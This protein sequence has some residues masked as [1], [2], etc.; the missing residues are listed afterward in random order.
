MNFRKI[1]LG[2]FSLLLLFSSCKKD[3]D[4]GGPAVVER[5]RTE[6]QLIDNDSLVGYLETHYYNSSL[7][8][9]PG[10]YG[11]SDIVIE[12]LDQDEDG[13]YLPL[14]DP[15]NTTLL[16]DAVGSPRT[17]T[18]QDVEYT[19]YVLSLNEGGGVMP[20]FCDSVRLNY[21]GM[22]QD[23][24]VFDST[25]TPATFDLMQ[26]I[27]GWRLVI[28]E[29]KTAVGNPSI[30]DDGIITYENYGLGVMFLPSGL[31]YYGSTSG[32]IS[33][34]SNLIFKF[35]LFQTE[36]NDHDEDLVPTYLE[37]IDGEDEL[38]NDDTD[39]DDIPD[40]VDID[41]DGDGVATINEVRTYSYSI[42]TT[43]GEEDP[44]LA[45]N[46]YVRKRTNNNGIITLKTVV[47]VDS[48]SN[49]VPDYLQESI[50]VNLNE[51]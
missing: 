12:E 5:D 14:E 22:L 30:G 32:V 6:Q 19:Y 18:Y 45:E 46:E 21:S 24:E 34:Y 41:D 2:V 48:D 50:A 35:E 51:D 39:G 11:I 8:E 25:V 40:F 13:N 43:I 37:D 26:L 29:F 7:F 17:T 33:A 28:P 27:E 47:L 4:G 31:G 3:D 16:I 44:L 15:E 23:H 36:L 9:T 42:D 20:N 38:Y 1:T 49:D 10:N